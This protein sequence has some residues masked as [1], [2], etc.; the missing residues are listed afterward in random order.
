MKIF[1]YMR[2]F[3]IRYVLFFLL[4]FS[5][6]SRSVFSSVWP[7][8][9]RG[10]DKTVYAEWDTWSG[11]T[12]PSGD[13]IFDPDWTG[14]G[15]GEMKNISIQAIQ[16]GSYLGA[17]AEVLS[18]YHGRQNVL[19]LNTDGLYVTVPNCLAGEYTLVRFEITYDD[20]FAA[21]AGLKLTAMTDQ[22]ALPGYNN[23]PVALQQIQR[24]RQDTWL[25]EVYEF[26]IDP[27]PEWEIF[28]LLFTHYPAYPLWV[29]AP[30][31]DS[32]SFDTICIPEPSGLLFL[33]AG[34]AF[35]ARYRR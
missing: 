27:S 32:F 3:K 5:S 17:S 26:V 28:Y 1:F 7:P 35:L 22:G 24:L 16:E 10:T 19:K 23:V 20:T 14:F 6:A 11:R 31:I 2:T 21:F 12:L 30:Y 29:D 33:T 9:W 4:F 18:E 34:A 25:T 13:M 8:S 15:A